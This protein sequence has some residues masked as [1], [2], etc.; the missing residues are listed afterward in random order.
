MD[1]IRMPGSI[2]FLT[3]SIV[4]YGFAVYA[5]FSLGFSKYTATFIV[6]LVRL[7]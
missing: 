2:L 4:I 7:S 3:A 5:F 1:K 6:E